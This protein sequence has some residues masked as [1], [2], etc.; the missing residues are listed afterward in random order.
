MNEN[1]VLD[2]AVV[3]KDRA[4]ASK[5]Y[6]FKTFD[7]MAWEPVAKRWLIKG[8]LARGESSAWIAPPGGAKSALMAQASICV[9]AGLDW[10]GK[11]LRNRHEYSDYKVFDVDASE[12]IGQ[13]KGVSEVSPAP[14]DS[15]TAK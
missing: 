5:G 13:P 1:V 12:K 2:I 15:G 4:Q 3:Q 14:P 7:E 11:R 8:V 9:A 6:P 10:N